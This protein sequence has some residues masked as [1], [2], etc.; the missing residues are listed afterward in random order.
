[1]DLPG[2]AVL[3]TSTVVINRGWR[4]YA[5]GALG[6]FGRGWFWQPDYSWGWAPFITDG[7]VVMI[8]ADGS[9]FRTGFGGRL[10]VVAQLGGPLRLG[11]AAVARVV[12]WT[13]D[14]GLT[15]CAVGVDFDFG[16]E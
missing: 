1:V 11:A 9:G 15:A 16:L 6:L 4:P 3:A 13:A 10:G 14:S 5:T 12:M 2:S 8:V 7:G